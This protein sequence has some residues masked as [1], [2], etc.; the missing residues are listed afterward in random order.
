MFGSDRNLRVFHKFQ[1][2]SAVGGISK[3]V[4]P[5]PLPRSLTRPQHVVLDHPPSQ[6][7]PQPVVI[8]YSIVVSQCQTSSRFSI[9]RWALFHNG[10][11]ELL[12]NH[13][14][15]IKERKTQATA[16]TCEE[17]VDNPVN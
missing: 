6:I 15:V 11:Q 10:L 3:G 14:N 1:L 2:F 17:E 12:K 9:P 8:H 13:L 16:T 5:T 7:R 4:R